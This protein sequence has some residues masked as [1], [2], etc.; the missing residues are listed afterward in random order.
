MSTGRRWVV[1][2]DCLGRALSQWRDMAPD[3][4]TR[5]RVSDRLIDLWVDPLAVG[6]EDPDRPGIFMARVPGTKVG[7]HFVLDMERWNV[8][9][10]SIA[11]DD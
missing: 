5:S 8:C 10:F 4:L 2:E 11:E 3:P 7:V 9:V 1:D 6:Q